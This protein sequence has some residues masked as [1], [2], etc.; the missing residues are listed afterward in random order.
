MA[1]MMSNIAS[2]HDEA[3]PLLAGD[4]TRP[5]PSKPARS[6]KLLVLIVCSIVILSWDFG[7]YLSAA[8]QIQIFEQIIC[9]KYQADLRQTANATQ[10]ELQDDPCKSEAVQGE[11]ALVNGYKESF[12]MLPSRFHRG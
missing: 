10:I 3:E 4:S 1:I 7:F 11:L 5:R 9:Q 12:D 8:P 2:D 6:K